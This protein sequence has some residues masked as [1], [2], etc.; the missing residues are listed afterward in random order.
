MGMRTA[1]NNLISSAMGRMSK[2]RLE[3][4]IKITVHIAETLSRQK[5]LLKLCRALMS[6]G[7]PTHRLGTSFHFTWDIP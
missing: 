2:P 4:A 5:Y 6:Y 3:D 1:S 7:A